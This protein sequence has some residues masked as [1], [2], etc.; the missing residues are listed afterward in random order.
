MRAILFENDDNDSSYELVC[1]TTHLTANS[2]ISDHLLKAL[3]LGMN[4]ILPD[5]ES[6]RGEHWR[7][8][9]E[10]SEI[11]RKVTTFFDDDTSEQEVKDAFSSQVILGRE[12]AF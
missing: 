6:H 11:K 12:D 2:R 10:R 5:T 3:E 8:N 9:A 1:I 7:D 4:V